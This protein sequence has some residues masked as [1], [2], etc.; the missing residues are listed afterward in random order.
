MKLLRITFENI[1]LFEHEFS[2][3]FLAPKS[4]TLDDQDKLYKLGERFY[5]NPVLAFT[6]LNASGKTIALNLLIFVLKMMQNIPLNQISEKRALHMKSDERIGLKVFFQ[7]KTDAWLLQSDITKTADPDERLVF[8]DE[9]LSVYK[10]AL[11]KPKNRLFDLSNYKTAADR[12]SIAKYLAADGSMIVQFN[13]EH[14]DQLYLCENPNFTNHRNAKTMLQIPDELLLFFDP[15]IEYLKF[16]SDS[17]QKKF[18]GARL[19]F[20]GANEL[21]LTSFDDLKLY[22]SAGTL[23]GLGLFAS[24][25][26]VMD[27]GGYLVVDDLES[28]LH[29]QIAASLIKMFLDPNINKNGGTLV[30]STHNPLLLDEMDRNDCIYILRKTGRSALT[31]LDE[32]LSRKDIKKSDAFI[33]GYLEGTAPDYVRYRDLRRVVVKKYREN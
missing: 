21:R 31:R 6:G 10:G 2:I 7:E 18:T 32:V 23:K 1:P 4:I 17:S 25:F 13:N 5:I 27:H 12:K 24:A 15:S 16:D 22:L 33:S 14:N 20:Y 29:P 30:F 8:L 11:K 26:S 3:D 28:H 19:K 9:Q